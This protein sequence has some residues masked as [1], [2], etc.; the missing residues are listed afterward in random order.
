MP[1]LRSSFSLP[2]LKSL[3]RSLGRMGQQ[4]AQGLRHAIA[5][6]ALRPGER[7][8]STR[9]LSESL[10]VSRGMIVEA[11]DQLKAEGYLESLPRAGTAVA[12][13]LHRSDV[14][15]T[16]NDF[17]ITPRPKG[18][19]PASAK[20]FSAVEQM[21]RPQA[22]LPLAIAHPADAAAPDE[23]WRRLGNR[24][25][26]TRAA[27]PSG[28]IDPRGVP[29]LREAIAD[30]VRRARAVR[31]TP[32]QV[33]I[34]AGTQQGLF[35]SAQ[36]L[37]GRGD[38]V[39]VE[40]PAYPGITAVLGTMDVRVTHVR[41]DQNGMDVEE[42]RDLCPDARAAFVTPSH[43]YPLG[44]PMSMGRRLSL[45]RWAEE[46]DAWIVE[47]DYDS[48]LRYAGHPFP[49]LQGLDPSRVIYLGTM[50]KVLFSSMRIGYAIVPDAL[51]AAFGGARAVVDR[52]SPSADQHV[53]A[54]FMKEGH[55]EAHI[56]RIRSAYSERRNALMSAIAAYL[57]DW[58]RLQP[59]DQ[60]MHLVV[61]LPKGVNDVKVSS[62]AREAGIVVRPISPLY[63]SGKGRA[64]LML[65][66]GG[67]SIAALER[68]AKDLGQLLRKHAP[69]VRRSAAGRSAKAGKAR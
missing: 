53:L 50:S 16:G 4:L 48:E 7:L 31:C 68:A 67:F 22:G 63:A 43:Q 35:L 41:V 58:A 29:E 40:D 20:R 38:A 42:A 44:M 46:A 5:S 24:V 56:R 26:A 25:R 37:L 10:G 12:R 69:E 45:L 61:W 28:Y 62:D 6:G 2:S 21:L 39:W 32:E 64:G 17:K 59:S 11:F 30:H 13:E 23:T 9:T 51:V 27:A 60:G 18:R 54:A 65:G 3:D 34:T 33:I 14:E 66:F 47:D 55:L 15:R 52:H 49:S 57:P 1:R 36:L 8:P 19:L